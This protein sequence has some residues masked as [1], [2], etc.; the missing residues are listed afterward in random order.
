MIHNL[1][2]NILGVNGQNNVQNHSLRNL[3]WQK[4][5]MRQPSQLS[6]KNP[7]NWQQ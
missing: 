2:K 3:F 5:G 4:K 6:E 7:G 1:L